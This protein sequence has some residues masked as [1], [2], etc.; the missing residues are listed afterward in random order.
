MYL[1]LLSPL[2]FILEIRT[3]IVVFTSELHRGQ[4]SSVLECLARDRGATGSSLIDVTV[5]CP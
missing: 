4:G 3:I 2:F 1:D 5:L